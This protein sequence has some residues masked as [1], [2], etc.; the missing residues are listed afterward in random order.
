MASHDDPTN[1]DEAGDSSSLFADRQG[2][3]RSFDVTEPIAEAFPPPDFTIDAGPTWSDEEA[4]AAAHDFFTQLAGTRDV[5]PHTDAFDFVVANELLLLLSD[6]HQVSFEQ[7]YRRMDNPTIRRWQELLDGGRASDAFGP[8]SLQEQLDESQLVDDLK[9]RRRNRTGGIV[10]GLVVLGLLAV[11]ATVFFNGDT[12]PEPDVSFTFEDPTE[13]GSGGAVGSPKPNISAAVVAPIISPIVVTAGVGPASDRVV[14]EPSD[15]LFG[16]EFDDVHF[17]L[18]AEQGQGRVALIGPNGW[19]DELCIVVSAVS[20]QLR[21]LDTTHFGPNA[22]LCGV[23]PIGTGVDAVCT[24]PNVVMLA[25]EIAQGQVELDEGGTAT[26]DSVR[27]RILRTDTDYEQVSRR[28]AIDLSVEGSA[29][30]PAFAF[31]STNS[32]ELD[33]PITPTENV[34]TTCTAEAG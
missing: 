5:V 6:D 4:N 7:H 31:S 24:G 1:E 25:L 13:A 17:V 27:A 15:T 22:S 26:V 20:A 12:E 11:A 19:Y 34:V 18:L 9:T 2:F 8:L 30:I 3:F 16:D 33:V 21:P 14:A 29:I 23:N 32:V 10:A 28:G